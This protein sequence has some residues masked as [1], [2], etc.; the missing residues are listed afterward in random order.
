VVGLE[1]TAA[2]IRL[3]VATPEGPYAFD[4]DW[5]IAADGARSTIREL[6]G[7]RFAGTAFD[8]KFLVADVCMAAELPAE[9]RFWFDPPFHDG[10]SALMHRQ[11]GNL[12]RIDLQLG[13]DA[14]ADLEQQPARVAARLERM[15]GHRAFELEWVSVYR[16]ACRRLERFVHDRILFAGDA[17]HEMSPFGARGGNS[18]VQD[19]DNLVWKLAAVATGTAPASLLDTY[20]LERGQAANENLA[21]SAGA[22][23]FIAPRSPAAR[24][25]RNAVLALAP[26]AEF[27][28]RMVNSGRLSTAAR[29]DTPLSTA[30][31]A[32]FAG[33][34]RLGGAAPDAPVA[35][36]FL[37][38]RLSGELEVLHV[39]DGA[40]PRV[41]DG[42]RMT[43]MDDGQP[44]GLFG[45]RYD[46][47]PG[48]TYLLRPDQHVAARWRRYD[49]A[50]LGAAVARVLGR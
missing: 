7:L 15:L 26:D 33:S 17:A 30:D 20:D 27:A 3:A 32:P 8:D 25:L 10:Q 5:V 45:Q 21:F 14:D 34:A 23:D 48:V 22:T 4:A 49:P 1:R 47:S 12:W 29:Y 31:E 42:V 28:R 11:P 37:T 50:K 38:E 18:G 19:A 46:A 36:G 16:Y 9:R 24:A 41:P 40:L 2:R 39:R 43:V 6:L 44:G 13:P 35:D